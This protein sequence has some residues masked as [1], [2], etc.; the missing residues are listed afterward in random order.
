MKVTREEQLIRSW[1][2]EEAAAHVHGWDF[3][4]IEGRY[5]TGDDLP[6]DYD[7]IVREYLR[8]DMT[9]LDYD[10]GGGE[11]LRSL[12]HPAERTSAT[13]GYPKREALPGGPLA[14]GH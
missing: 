3:S 2:R 7:G 4:H 12:G 9:L 14:P 10:T 1:K 5:E 13:E 8:D 11:F 6:W